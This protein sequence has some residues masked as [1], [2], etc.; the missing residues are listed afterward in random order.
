MSQ[1]T[2][3]L[4]QQ[5]WQL[6]I[7]PLLTVLTAYIVKFINK[8]SESLQ[9]TT[10]NELYKKYIMLLDDTIA[11]CVIATNQTYVD[12]LKDKNAFTKEAQEKAFKQ[13]Y[14]AVMAI[15]SIEAKTYLQNAVGDLDT[16]I[17]NSI[18]AQVK[19]NKTSTAAATTPQVIAV[20]AP[21]ENE[22]KQENS[23]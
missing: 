10:D 6:C 2:Q 18:Q 19:I 11:K 3:A 8:K 16:Y 22:K 20:A 12:S 21:I 23:N 17:R 5:I 1:E 15:L 4:L 9:K 7:I 13:S 14:D